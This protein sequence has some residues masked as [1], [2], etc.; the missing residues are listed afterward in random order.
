MTYDYN[1]S[2]YILLCGHFIEKLIKQEAHDDVRYI[3][4]GFGA[5]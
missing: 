5:Y 3:I 4:M 2:K 1:V